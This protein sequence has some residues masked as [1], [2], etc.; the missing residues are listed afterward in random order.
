M[1][2]KVIIY[3]DG[4][5]KG[6]PGIGGWG[7]ILMYKGHSKEICGYENNVTNNQMELKAAIKALSI[8]KKECEIELHTD[9]KYLKNGIECW[10]EN[11]IKNDWKT[12]AKKPVKNRDLWVKIHNLNL[13]YKIT[14]KWVKGHSGDK[15]NEIADSLANKAILEKIKG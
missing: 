10:L 5:C 4:A 11:W 3:T 12:S 1:T 13:Q 2:Q 8:L 7:A 15:Y 6:N 9:S 14:W